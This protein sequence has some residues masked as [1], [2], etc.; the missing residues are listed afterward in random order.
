LGAIGFGLTL[1]R[2]GFARGMGTA[3]GVTPGSEATMAAAATA[4]AG[5]VNARADG[6][7]NSFDGR[8]PAPSLDLAA[9]AV[10]AGAG[11]GAAAVA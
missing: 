6:G 1:G 5:L 10:C 4:P 9:A 8:M 2:F 11:G 3:A 7:M